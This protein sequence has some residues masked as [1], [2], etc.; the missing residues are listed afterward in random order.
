MPEDTYYLL[1]KIIH[2]HPDFSQRQ[3]SGELGISLG[4]VNYCLRAL[5]DKGWLKTGS[6]RRNENKTRNQ[7]LVTPRGLREKT[8]LTAEFL[9]RKKRE[10][11][12]LKMEIAEL[13]E[14]VR[15]LGNSG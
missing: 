13:T 7:Y 6:D 9:E 15:G 12:R 3:L 8:R 11:A 2:E 1:L 14:E 5:I 10:H 4:K